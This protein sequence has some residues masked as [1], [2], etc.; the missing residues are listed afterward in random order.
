MFHRSDLIYLNSMYLVGSQS[1]WFPKNKR[2]VSF[3]CLFNNKAKASET[4]YK[5]K[6]AYIDSCLEYNRLQTG[7][8]IG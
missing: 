4:E 5:G 7:L 2:V 1:G 6:T 8:V 3:Q